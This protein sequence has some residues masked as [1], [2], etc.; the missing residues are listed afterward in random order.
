MDKAN[1]QIH[2]TQENKEWILSIRLYPRDTPNDVITR[3][4]EKMKRQNGVI[5][6]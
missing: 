3:L 5:I 2:L 4:R 1:K 6:A